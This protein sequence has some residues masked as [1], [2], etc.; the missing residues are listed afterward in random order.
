MK[1]NKNNTAR[2]ST[3]TPA[4]VLVENQQLRVRRFLDDEDTDPVV[5]NTDLTA[6]PLPS[7][8]SPSTS[9]VGMTSP[10]QTSQCSNLGPLRLRPVAKRALISRR[11]YNRRL[12]S[13]KNSQKT[14]Y[15]VSQNVS[16]TTVS[17][18][19]NFPGG[20]GIGKGGLRRADVF[21]PQRPRSFV[22]FRSIRAAQIISNQNSI[23]MAPFARL[24][25]EIFYR[26]QHED[27]ELR[28][29][30]SIQA[31]R[32]Q[33]AAIECLRDAGEAFLV[34]FFER[35]SVLTNHGGRVTLMPKDFALALRIDKWEKR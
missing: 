28:G 31:Q 16:T 11:K 20:F 2:K 34:N 5:N 17:T 24:I 29:P 7:E 22:P 3:T 8:P 30:G 19:R 12:M 32:F 13:I 25:K 1:R 6:D 15:E 26:V 35:C 23:P 9:G 4:R 27:E 21:R 10:S 33:L 14:T 18:R